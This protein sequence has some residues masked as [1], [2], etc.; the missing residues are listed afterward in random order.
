MRS[1]IGLGVALCL[2]AP[3]A[4]AP[5]KG[6]AAKDDLKAL[7]GSWE[8]VEYEVGGEKI[9]NTGHRLTIKGDKFTLKFKDGRADVTGTV[10]VTAG[11]D[12]HSVDVTLGD[13]DFKGKKLLGIFRIKD[14][15]QE[16]CF[17]MPGSDRPTNFETK[18]GD[19]RYREVWQ[20][21]TD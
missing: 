5:A 1:L 15:K 17:A 10:A 6:D 14:G 16:T 11:K 13:G 8:L 2:V 9:D 20:R 21:A 7:Q 19:N 18:P 3:S 12:F 4:A